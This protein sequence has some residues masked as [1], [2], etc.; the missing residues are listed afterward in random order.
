M[1]LHCLYTHQHTHTQM[2]APTAV[3]PNAFC[4]D[5]HANLCVIVCVC[6]RVCVWNAQALRWTWSAISIKAD[7]NNSGKK[8]QSCNFPPSLISHW[9][10]CMCV[11]D[12]RMA[13]FA[14]D[15]ERGSDRDGDRNGERERRGGEE[16]RGQT[17]ETFF[18]SLN[19]KSRAA[20]LMVIG[21]SMGWRKPTVEFWKWP[22]NVVWGREK[23]CDR[24][25]SDT[26]GATHSDI[27]LIY[28]QR[29]IRET[30]CEWEKNT[31][32]NFD[33]W[34]IIIVK[35]LLFGQNK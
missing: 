24:V 32:Y 25:D 18:L 9:R 31:K 8:T 15:G 23:D 14:T 29:E 33:K 26:S 21:S 34:L 27:N 6:V 22:A 28:C 17:R 12:R 1:R 30:K 7:F 13:C 16:R 35:M 11:L 3:P 5:S 10:V 4:L 19:A 2:K 20:K